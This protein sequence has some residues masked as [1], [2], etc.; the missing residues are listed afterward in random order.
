MNYIEFEKFKEE[1]TDPEEKRIASA[2]G[3]AIGLQAVDGLN[4]SEKL[5]DVA[6]RNIKGEITMAEATKIIENNYS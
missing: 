3:T 6:V 1:L 5:L 2:W 4:V